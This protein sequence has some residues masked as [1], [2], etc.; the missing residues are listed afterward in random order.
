M[1]ASPI[2]LVLHGGAGAKRSQDYSRE[3]PHMQGLVEAARDR[4]R[5]GASALDVAVETVH[6]LEQSGLYVA[7]RGSSPNTDGGYELDASV[8]DGPGQRAGAV[9]ALQGFKSPVLVARRVMEATPHVLLAGQ[10]AADFAKAQ[11]MDP[12]PGNDWFTHAGATEDNHPPALSH[13]TVGC[14]VLDA[15]GRLAA[16]TS[17]GGVFGKMPG[18]VGDTPIIGSGTWAD[19]SA[20]VSSTGTGEFFLRTVAAAQVAWRVGAGQPLDE[21]ARKVIEAVGALGGDGGIIAVDRAGN[22]T[23]PYN[24]EGMKRAWLTRDGEVGVQVF[25][26]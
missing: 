7:G 3:I 12:V 6:A 16:A 18:R 20:A 15:D 14:T 10:G 17:T 2:A 25:D 11:R 21:A 26:A 19:G 13:G 24:S 9:A 23:H 1:P 5:A 22:V 8:M 4:L